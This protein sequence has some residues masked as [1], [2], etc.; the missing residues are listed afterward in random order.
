MEI[1][2]PTIRISRP[3]ISSLESLARNFMHNVLF[4]FRSV[5]LLL[6][7]VLCFLRAHN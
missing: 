2:S 4:L 3:L 5:Q 7:K 6:P 1:A